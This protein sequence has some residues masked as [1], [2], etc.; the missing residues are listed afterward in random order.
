MQI[1]DIILSSEPASFLARAILV[2]QAMQTGE[3]ARWSHACRYAGD[4]LVLSQEARMVQKPLAQLKGRKRRW[5]NP[6][7]NHNQRHTM[8]SDDRLYLGEP[9]DVLGLVGQLMRVIPWAGP[10]LASRVQLPHL[11]Y[12]SERV[13]LTERIVLP[14]F[15]GGGPC[16]VTPQGINDWCRAAGWHCEDL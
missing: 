14:E 6:A 1:G 16:V 8:V 13:C 7:Y 12:C 15:G 11:T 2:G 9:Y 5:H 4:G 3:P 10:W